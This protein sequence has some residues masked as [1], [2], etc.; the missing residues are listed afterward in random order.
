V[1]EQRQLV[2]GL[3]RAAGRRLLALLAAEIVAPLREASR[4]AVG[5][6]WPW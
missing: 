4:Q 2:Q 1:R 6:F 5:E 3:D